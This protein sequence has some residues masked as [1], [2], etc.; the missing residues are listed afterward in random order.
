[1]KEFRINTSNRG[2]FEEFKR[3]FSRHGIDLKATHEDLKE[4]VADPVSV[5]ANKASN[6]GELVLVEDTSLD[7]EGESV[8]IHIRAL[9]QDLPRFI[10][11]RALFRSLIAYREGDLVYIFSG[12]VQGTIVPARGREGFG[13]DPH[14]LPDGAVKTLGESK[15]DAFNARA[16]AVNALVRGDHI[17]A[18]PAVKEWNGPWQV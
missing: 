1:M 14:F 5:V 6:A 11:K 12:E 17:K 13:F 7:I 16:I 9:L 18:V 2:K 8:G 10:G 4:I 15:P 3:L